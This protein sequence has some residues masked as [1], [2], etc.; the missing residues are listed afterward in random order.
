MFLLPYADHPMAALIWLGLIFGPPAG[1]I[2][3]LPAEVLRPENRAAGMGLF[4]SI[5]YGGMMALTSLAGYSRDLTQN[6]A[7]PILFGG[8][9]LI[10]AIMILAI[11]RA[12]QKRIKLIPATDI[13]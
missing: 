6:A 7:T 9:L 4:Y 1:I 3:A 12:I 5:H 10:I 8:M 13:S 2:M 11:F